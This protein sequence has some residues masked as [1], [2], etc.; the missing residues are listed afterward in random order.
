MTTKPLKELTAQK[1][2]FAIYGWSIFYAV[3]FCSLI[4]Y[5]DWGIY[6]VVAVI[7]YQMTKNSFL[8]QRNAEE[9]NE[10]LQEIH[11]NNTFS[12]NALD[13]L[14]ME[15]GRLRKGVNTTKERLKELDP[16]LVRLIKEVEELKKWQ[17]ASPAP[18]SEQ[19][20]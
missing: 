12:G 17:M 1:Y 7:T 14:K 9:A 19:P 4:K 16:I 5:S 15:D 13:D 3:I 18:N 6:L 2:A 20:H 8:L 11:M 10:A